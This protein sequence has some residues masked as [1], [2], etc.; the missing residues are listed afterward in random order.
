MVSRLNARLF[1]EAL[2][3][4]ITN[5]EPAETLQQVRSS[6]QSKP[7]VVLGGLQPGQSTTAVAALCAEYVKA[8][9]IIFST[10]VDGVYDA[11]P[12]EVKTAKLL[13]KV[14][15][16]Q[17]RKLTGLENSNPGQYQLMDGVCLTILERSKIPSVILRGTGENILNAIEGKDVGTLIL[18]EN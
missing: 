13:K 14:N 12:K 2:G 10:D 18:Q 7:I 4:D 1:I 5:T 9:R 3:D 11:N 16:D 8:E 17:L 6:L 15:Y